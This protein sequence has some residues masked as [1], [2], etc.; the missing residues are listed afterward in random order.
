M[1]PQRMARLLEGEAL[2]EDGYTAI[3]MMDDLREGIWS[4][5][6]QGRDIDPYRRNRQRAY[7]ERAEYLMTQEVSYA[8]SGNRHGWTNVDVS[9]SDIRAIVR[10]QLR[11]LNDDVERAARRNSSRH[12]ALHLEDI[13][14]RIEQILEPEG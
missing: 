7:L 1:H 10:E 11:M 6:Y 3:A 2:F 12:T 13:S 9:Q 8:S 4:E 14:Y 5:I